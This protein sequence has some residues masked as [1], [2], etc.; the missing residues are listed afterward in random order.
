[1]QPSTLLIIAAFPALL[2]AVMGTSKKC[3][4]TPASG[5]ATDVGCDAPFDKANHS[6]CTTFDSDCSSELIA[7]NT[8]T[9]PTDLKEYAQFLG[10]DAVNSMKQAKLFTHFKANIGDF[11]TTG[12]TSVEAHADVFDGLDAGDFAKLKPAVVGIISKASFATLKDTSFTLFGKA[13]AGAITEQQ[14]EV[15]TKAQA[16]KF[17]QEPP[18]TTTKAEDFKKLADDSACRVLSTKTDKMKA[19]GTADA[20]K[21]RCKWAD[22]SAAAIQVTLF[23]TFASLA[24]VFLMNTLAF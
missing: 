17:G 8:K 22:N 24:S 6:K 9:A 18:P 14:L 5:T 2:S 3:H 1:M 21:A 19:T 13:T 4:Y 12:V 15:M 7:A 16:D 23:L 20:F 10:K 11:D